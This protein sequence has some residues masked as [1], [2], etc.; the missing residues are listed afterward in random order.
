TPLSP[1][2]QEFVQTIQS[3]AEVLLELINDVLDF[4]KIEAGRVELEST[5]IS[6]HA[7]GEGR[8]G[9]FG[10]RARRKGLSLLS[11]FSPQ[12]PNL[13]QGDQS[14]IRQILLNLLSNAIKFTPRGEVVLK[15]T[16][17]PPIDG[18]VMLHFVVS[19][20]G[21]G[22]NSKTVSQ[23]FMPFSQADGSIT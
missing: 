12:I 23:L 22:M 20:T 9:V 10:D 1:D 11:Y 13:V 19:D 14:R 4:S 2:Q 15:V 8:A 16:A 6:L 5:E 21:I 18:H 3:S 7:L 17:E